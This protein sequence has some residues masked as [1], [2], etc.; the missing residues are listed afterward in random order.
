MK[1]IL[2]DFLKNFSF[3]LFGDGAAAGDGGAAGGDSGLGQTAE[4]AAQ[5]DA[6]PATL[7]RRQEKR[8]PLAEL[9]RQP[10]DDGSASGAP[11]RKAVDVESEW[12][13][14]K[15]GKFAAQY[16]R[17]V[18]EAVN[19]RFRKQADLQGQLDR[20]QPVLSALY[21]LNG[22][23]DGDFDAL[24]AR[25]LDDDSL[26][27]DDAMEHGMS[28]DAYKEFSAIKGERDQ[29]VAERQE[30]QTRAAIN[31]HLQ[32]L[33]AQEAELQKVFPGFSLDTE[34]Q[35]PAF[36]EMTKPGSQV[37]LRQAYYAIHGDELMPQTM[38]KGVQ[39]AQQRL[40]NAMAANQARPV[41]GGLNN[42]GGVTLS[43]D[44]RQLTR[45]QRQAIRERVRRGERVIL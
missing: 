27:E 8:D 36:F 22:I 38:A 7:H 44:P 11:G 34:M 14:A 26:Y 40:A 2:V 17:D 20:M 15:K 1:G 12:A 31:Q 9:I 43:V 29:M 10:E 6:R 32:N 30:A 39:V 24:S 45:E 41:E 5:Q 42:R 25:I 21:K 4:P 37:N 23:E 18:Q 28:I 35:N 33:R 3:R 16:G 19:Q 13:E